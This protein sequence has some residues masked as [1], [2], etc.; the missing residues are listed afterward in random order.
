MLFLNPFVSWSATPLLADY[1]QI[2]AVE[3]YQR[4]IKQEMNELHTLATSNTQA[5][6]D[7]FQ[8]YYTS[9]G[10]SELNELKAMSA[11]LN[12]M[13]DH[14]DAKDDC[15][16]L[17]VLSAIVAN[18]LNNSA[19]SK[20]RRK[21]ATN[22]V[23]LLLIDRNMDVSTV[24]LFH[25]ETTFDKISNL[26]P[27]LCA[28]SNDVHIDLREFLFENS[29]KSILPGTFFHFSTD[30]CRSLVEQFMSARPKECL[31][32]VYK[33]LCE[34]LPASDGGK[35]KKMVRINADGLKTQMRNGIKYVNACNFLNKELQFLK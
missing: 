2:V 5:N 3:T 9:F 24:S 1:N 16:S 21:T 15:F 35:D 32:D 23:S 10:A 29:F 18:E 20:Q 12:E 13:L 28:T 22:K 11:S 31:L 6:K 25:E 14:L 33:R 26:M 19:V 34:A 30:S 17:G 7:H 27:N 4:L 8:P